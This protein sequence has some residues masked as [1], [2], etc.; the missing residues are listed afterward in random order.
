MANYGHCTIIENPNFYPEQAAADIH[1]ALASKDNDTII[2]H[3]TSISNPQRQKLREAYFQQFDVELDKAIDKKLSGDLEKLILA[4]IDTP[5]EY[6][7]KQI[8]DAMKGFGTDEN[9]LIEIL[10]TRTP[11]QMVHINS[12]FHTLFKKDLAKEIAGDTSGDFKKLLVAL[13]NGSKD[14]SRYI[15]DSQAREDAHFLYDDGKLKTPPSHF[16]QILETQ[17]IHQ[18]RRVFEEFELHTG[19]SIE[20]AVAKEF[21]GDLGDG[22]LAIVRA[23]QNK[24]RYFALQLEK[25]TK[26]SVKDNDLIRVLVSRS[27]VDLKHIQEEYHRH[28]QKSLVD[29]ITA[30]TKGP[31][32]DAL[33]KILHGN[34]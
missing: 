24:Q 20:D 6:D 4:L 31:Y 1:A 21:K 33:L 27:E 19:K 23:T 3:L 12:G 15:H 30:E 29:V 11:E 34:Y 9:T 5:L 25:A 28:H 10:C 16:L 32:R 8:K 17:N 13:V 26:G 14:G 7:L 22:L 2:N 18:L